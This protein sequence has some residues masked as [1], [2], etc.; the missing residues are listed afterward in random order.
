MR[1]RGYDGREPL[2]GSFFLVI[3][4]IPASH[5]RHQSRDTTPELPPILHNLNYRQIKTFTRVAVGTSIE[6]LKM[7]YHA[8]KANAIC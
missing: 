2:S 5:S 4:L 7:P 6:V 3:L 1:D 8:P